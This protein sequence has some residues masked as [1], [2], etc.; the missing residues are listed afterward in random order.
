MSEEANAFRNTKD[1]QTS[2]GQIYLAKNDRLD[3][4]K[5]VLIKYKKR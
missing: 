5:N 3:N 4:K 2:G 1:R